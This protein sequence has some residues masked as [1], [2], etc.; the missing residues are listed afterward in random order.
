MAEGLFVMVVSCLLRL[1]GFSLTYTR[2]R[3]ARSPQGLYQLGK[4]AFTSEKAELTRLQ[5]KPG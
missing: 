3:C 2:W 4:L 1:D 5:D